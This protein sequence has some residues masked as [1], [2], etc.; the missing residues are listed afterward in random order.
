MDD[1]GYFVQLDE[2]GRPPTPLSG[3]NLENVGFIRVAP[4]K[5]GLQD[6]LFGNRFAELFYLRVVDM[7]TRLVAAWD[8]K[9]RRGPS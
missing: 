4:D 7:V 6:T 8:A 3:D 5:N 9:I 1:D 2:L